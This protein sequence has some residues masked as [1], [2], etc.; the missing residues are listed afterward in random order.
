MLVDIPDE[1]GFQCVR[2][3]DH[4]LFCAEHLRQ[5]LQ[6]Q[7]QISQNH[8]S[9]LRGRDSHILQQGQAAIIFRTVKISFAGRTLKKWLHQPVFR[10][11]GRKNAGIKVQQDPLIG[12]AGVDPYIVRL[13]RA[14]Q[15]DI[16]RL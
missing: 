4:R 6:K 12:S 5:L 11:N 2:V 14:Y 10:I 8:Q 1:L 13:H 16:A 15:Y 3:I 7:D 9:W